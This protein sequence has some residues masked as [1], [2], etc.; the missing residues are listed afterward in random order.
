MELNAVRWLKDLMQVL[1]KCTG[2][3][4][5][6]WLQAMKYLADIHKYTIDETLGYQIPMSIWHPGIIHD[7]AIPTVHVLGTSL[8]SG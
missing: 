7:F 5:W 2:A 3:P 8:L 4:P 1:L 6:V